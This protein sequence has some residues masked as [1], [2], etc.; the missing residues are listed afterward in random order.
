[1]FLVAFFI[2][3]FD[4]VEAKNAMRKKQKKK[5]GPN[6]GLKNATCKQ[7]LNRRT[8]VALGVFKNSDTSRRF[9]LYCKDVK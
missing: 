6:N 2:P 1:M 3:P 5:N 7:S 4:P 8:L 9:G